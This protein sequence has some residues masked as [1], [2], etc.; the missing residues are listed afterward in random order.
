MRTH[1]ALLGYS[2]EVDA[3][4]QG[5]FDNISH[6][7]LLELLTILLAKALHIC[8]YKYYVSSNLQFVVAVFNC[9]TFVH[10]FVTLL[11]TVYSPLLRLFSSAGITVLPLL[12]LNTKEKKNG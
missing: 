8:K 7:F 1:L 11:P 2:R 6:N 9:N 5:C 10:A 3:D 12:P 4:I